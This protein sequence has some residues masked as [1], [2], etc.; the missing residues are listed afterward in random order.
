MLPIDPFDVKRVATDR[1]MSDAMWFAQIAVP[2][3]AYITALNRH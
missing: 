1:A 2:Q 3:L